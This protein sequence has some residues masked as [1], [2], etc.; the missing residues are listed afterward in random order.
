MELKALL[1]LQAKKPMEILKHANEWVKEEKNKENPQPPFLVI[2]TAHSYSEGWLLNYDESEGV[3]LLGSMDGRKVDLKYLYAGA[4][5]SLELPSAQGWLFKLSDGENEEFLDES[6]APSKLQITSHSKKVS[7][8]LS[9][10]LAKNL[11]IKV[12]T[13]GAH[14]EEA[15]KPVMRML[16]MGIIDKIK[17]VIATISE[18]EMGKEALQENVSEVLLVASEDNAISLESGT[19]KLTMDMRKGAK[20]I[21]SNDVMQE[22]IEEKL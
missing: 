5:E 17:T 7:D 22:K 4:I 6:S 21:W 12:D 15:M 18:E 1:S 14:G 19:L 13:E 8:V 9:E 10:L 16:W 3:V 20:G 11:S 2:R